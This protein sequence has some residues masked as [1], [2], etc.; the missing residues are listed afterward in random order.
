M[1]TGPGL[2]GTG[3]SA[4]AG[5]AQEAERAVLVGRMEDAVEGQSVE[6]ENTASA[7]V[8]PLAHLSTRK[9]CDKTE[10]LHGDSISEATPQR[11]EIGFVGGEQRW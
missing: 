2:E 1:L 3:R 8:A 9:P 6:V 10:G 7:S 5:Q 4:V 11:G